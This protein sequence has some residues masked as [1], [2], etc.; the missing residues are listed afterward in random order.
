MTGSVLDPPNTSG[1]VKCV[2]YLNTAIK[3]YRKEQSFS[4]VKCVYIDMHVIWNL[5]IL[6]K[7]G[8]APMQTCKH[9]D[10]DSNLKPFWC[11]RQQC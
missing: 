9:P 8:G 5:Q 11:F 6:V 4:S 2:R 7:H 1:D 10:L 3:T